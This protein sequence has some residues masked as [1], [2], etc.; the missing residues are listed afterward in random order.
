MTDLAGLYNM[1]LNWCRAELVTAPDGSSKSAAAC[2]RFYPSARDGVLRAYPWNSAAGRA[3]LAA[4]PTPAFEWAYAYT[5]PDDCVCLR[6]LYDDPAAL[7]VVEGREILCDLR[8][9]LRIRYTRRIEPRQMDPLLVGVVAARLAFDMAPSL[10]ESGTGTDAL[11]QRYQ[12]ML[13]EARQV[14]AK[15]GFAPPLPEQ[16]DWLA[17]RSLGGW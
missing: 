8:G 14:D 16:S 5:L 6:D 11:Y 15:E 17:S 12:A 1:A 2:G 13:R 10:T 9:P 4:G 7:H 3:Q